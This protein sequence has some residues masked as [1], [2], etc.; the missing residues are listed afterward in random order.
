MRSSGV[1][2]GS[3]WTVLF[4]SDVSGLEDRDELLL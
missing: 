1:G 2:S 4:V 3:S